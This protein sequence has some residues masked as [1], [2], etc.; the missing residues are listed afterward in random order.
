MTWK[1]LSSKKTLVPKRMSRQHHNIQQVIEQ[2]SYMFRIF[3]RARALLI[4]GFIS[5]ILSRRRTACHPYT[6]PDIAVHSSLLVCTS[7]P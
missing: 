2:C 1:L 6:L 7:P 4:R 3:H 5:W